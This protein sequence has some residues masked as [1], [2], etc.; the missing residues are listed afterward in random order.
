MSKKKLT[1]EII[2]VATEG[3]EI[4]KETWEEISLN[5]LI[6]LSKIKDFANLD[7]AGY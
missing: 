5:E 1:K 3:Q 7:M 2:K 6:K 4:F